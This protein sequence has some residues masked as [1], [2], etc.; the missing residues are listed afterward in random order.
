MQNTIFTLKKVEEAQKKPL[1]QRTSG[2]SHD[3]KKY[4]LFTFSTTA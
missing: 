4:L 2:L 3:Y 1:V